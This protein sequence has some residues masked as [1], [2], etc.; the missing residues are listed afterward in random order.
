MLSEELQRPVRHTAVPLSDFLTQPKMAGVEPAY[1]RCIEQT[2]TLFRNGTLTDIADV[3][4]D[5]FRVTGT[6]ATGLRAFIRRNLDVLA[7]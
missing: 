7:G 2:V 1:A 5:V 4:D 6:E 3:T